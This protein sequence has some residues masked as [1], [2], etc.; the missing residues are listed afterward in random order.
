[1][2]PPTTPRMGC[3]SRGCCAARRRASMRRRGSRVHHSIA[4]PSWDQHR[5]SMRSSLLVQHMTVGDTSTFERVALH[6]CL[7]ACGHG[8][9]LSPLLSLRW[10]RVVIDEAQMVESGTA[11]AAAMARRLPAM[12]RW[13]VSGTPM[14]RG[15]LA[16]WRT[17]PGH[18]Q[19]TSRDM[20]PQ[21]RPA[22]RPDGPDRLSADPAVERARLVEERD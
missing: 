15:R 1:M 21:A 10:W 2:Q 3:P 17:R 18:V 7:R 8:R 20:T 16:R 9:V 12:H 22:R 19:D 6:S 5:L 11:K 4:A 13:A 14:G